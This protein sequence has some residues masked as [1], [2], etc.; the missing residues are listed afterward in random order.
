MYE[1]LSEHSSDF[2]LY[3]FAFD[4]LTREI[5]L[6]YKLDN[7]TVVSLDEFETPEL[8]KVKQERSKAEYCWTCTSSTISYVLEKY[9]VADC[10]Y[11]D[12]DL[13]FYSDPAVLIA[14]LDGQERMFS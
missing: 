9:G 1:S 6:Q 13:I 11:V 4:E 14:E 2:H 10:T 3:V 7:V 12:S 8:K 5:L